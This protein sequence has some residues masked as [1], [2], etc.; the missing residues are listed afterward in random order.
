MLQSENKLQNHVFNMISFNKQLSVCV[1]VCVCARTH[2]CTYIGTEGK[3]WKISGGFLW[4][5]ADN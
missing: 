2:A 4:E 3:V 1:C 5:G